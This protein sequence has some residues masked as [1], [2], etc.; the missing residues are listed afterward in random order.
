MKILILSAYQDFVFRG[1]ERFVDEF[2]KKMGKKHEVFV[3]KGNFYPIKRVPIL[4]RMYLDPQGIKIFWFTLKNLHKIWREKFDL[5][6]P[7]NGGWQPALLR[8]L[9]WIRGGKLVI[10]GHSG[11]GWDDVNNLWCFPDTFVALSSYAKNWAKKVNPFVNVVYIPNGVDIEKFNP[12]GAKL[13]IYLKRPIVLFAAALE[14]G[15]RVGLLIDALSKIGNLSLLIAGKG[16]MEDKIRKKAKKL[17]KKRFLMKSFK[18]EDMP[19]VYRSCDLLVSTSLPVYSFEMVIV[20]AMASNL[21]VVANKD[22]IRSEIVGEAG[23]LVDCSKKDEIVK[24]IKRALKKNWDYI[25]RKRAEKFSWEEVI[26]KYENLFLRL[27]K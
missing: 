23:V 12:K 2:S 27:I 15:K 19:K 6:I 20:E 16:E 18:F 13:K 24:G 17:L 22:R 26:K 3:L 11:I 1:A 7:L 25:P 14:P 9:T 21:P 10:I 4:W 8:I 5:I